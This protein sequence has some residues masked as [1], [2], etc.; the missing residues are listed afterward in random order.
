MDMPYTTDG[1]MSALY[2]P[3][4]CEAFSNNLN[5]GEHGNNV[6]SNGHRYGCGGIDGITVGKLPGGGYDTDGDGTVDIRD[7]KDYI[8]VAM[9]PYGNA[10]RYDNENQI[11]M[12]FDP[13]NINS[14]NL[15]AFTEDNLTREYTKAEEY[16]YN[17]KMFLYVGNQKYGVQQLE[18]DRDTGDIWI[19]AYEK[20]EG[21]EFPDV[22][23]MVIDGSIPL[24]MEEVEVGQS[25]TG[26]ASGFVTQS[27]AKARAALYTDF[28]DA[29]NDGDTTEQEPGWHM[30]L[31]CTCG[32]ENHEAEVYG[33]TGKAAMVCGKDANFDTGFASV[34]GNLFYGV[35]HSN[36]EKDGVTYYGGTAQLYRL[37]RE[38][39][40]FNPVGVFP[41]TFEDF[42]DKNYQTDGF[43]GS[44]NA[45]LYIVPKSNAW[46]G[47]N[48]EIVP[49][50]A[51]A[52]DTLRFTA[53]VK[54]NN[55][56][57][58]NG[59][60]RMNFVA[61]S[62]G[63]VYKTSDDSS[64]PSFK[65]INAWIEKTATATGAKR[66]EWIQVSYEEEWNGKLWGKIPA[67]YNGNTTDKYGY[68]DPNGDFT[69]LELRFYSDCAADD[70][71]NIEYC[72]DDISFSIEPK[73]AAVSDT[74]GKSLLPDGSMASEE[75]VHKWRSSAQFVN[76]TSPDGSV[77]YMRFG[78][79]AGFGGSTLQ[80]ENVQYKPNHL[81]KYEFWARVAP[82][83]E[84]PSNA[85]NKTPNGV[86]FLQM[87]DGTDLTADANGNTH[88]Y[89]G[90]SAAEIT[91]EWKHFTYYYTREY[92]TFIETPNKI[93]LRFFESYADNG[94]TTTVFDL[95]GFKLTDL[96][97][98]TN[99]SFD[100][101]EE[102][103]FRS[104]NAYTA[105]TADSVFGWTA[106]NA[107]NS[108]ENGA[109]KVNVTADGGKVYQGIYM[110]NK[111]TYKLTFRAKADVDSEKPFAAV[112]DRS[113]TNT[114]QDAEIYEVPDYQY[115]TGKRDVGT[116]YKTS[117]WTISN[118]WKT[119]ECYISN[120]FDLMDGKS[121][122]VGIVPRT[123]F[124]YFNVDGNK[125]GTAYYID[126]VTLEAVDERPAL[127]NVKVNGTN[128]PGDTL[129][130]EYKY[131][132]PAGIDEACVRVRIVNKTDLGY[133]TLATLYANDTFVIPES[134]IG[135][136]LYAEFVAL[137][138]D[139]NRSEAQYIAINDADDW[140][141]NYYDAEN[142][143]ARVYASYSVS[144]NVAFAAYKDNALIS[145]KLVPAVIESAYGSD[146]AEPE[147][148]VTDT[149]D[150]I[151]VMFWK[152]GYNPLCDCVIVQ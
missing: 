123:P 76:E 33:K 68:C 38:N 109:M 85:S 31:K 113:V 19:E 141:K 1:L 127:S 103:I 118:D 83:S 151:K 114:G 23:R 101:G 106:E 146:T 117:G 115:I 139:G 66:G 35:T 148:F 50:T 7:D 89:P 6:N 111:G 44:K 69:R 55:S 22:S 104:T 10:K 58:K 108:L 37:D 94:G 137:D 100:V 29:D 112:L 5:A 43:C 81:Y 53:W 39:W 92:K 80:I 131:K 149:A 150:C 128:R 129:S 15:I 90:F 65:H 121:E 32:R 52:G 51:H 105:A 63:T 11:V 12:V 130:F 136:N 64:L 99:G 122:K 26:D 135:K 82:T 79:G 13:A 40:K 24:K 17:H 77:G 59:N 87:T 143:S 25:V 132:N 147:N 73:Y 3:Q 60:L 54:M 8:L 28:E 27:E 84:V 62:L 120:D 70:V 140:A 20:P 41:Y 72:I 96:G 18:Y 21:T 4:V 95:D 107:E 67:G 125:A 34:G 74:T 86:Y 49:G 75:I 145:V 48:I 152:D 98:V 142:K 9:G 124:L 57:V 47:G 71:E 45:G 56:D 126:D 119:Y 16:R 78:S 102:K 134:A 36:F 93:W 144:G 110:E 133:A 116:E 91:T 61:W 97:A 46:G 138:T 88:K 30:Y 14:D 42:E 2:L